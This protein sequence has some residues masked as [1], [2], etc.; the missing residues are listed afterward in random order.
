MIL[1]FESVAPDHKAQMHAPVRVTNS[2]FTNKV[3]AFREWEW[4]GPEPRNMRLNRFVA[5][6]VANDEYDVKYNGHVP[7]EIIHRIQ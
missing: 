6:A 3:N 5:L 7:S 1:E 4:D 2:L